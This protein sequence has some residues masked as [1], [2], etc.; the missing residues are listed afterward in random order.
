MTMSASRRFA[1]QFEDAE[2]VGLLFPEPV[3][4][5]EVRA[6]LTRRETQIVELLVSDLTDKEIARTL[7][8]THRTVRTHLERIYRKQRVRTRTGAVATWLKNLTRS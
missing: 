8:I 1:W 5:P 3:D 7:G 4:Y 6:E 2:G